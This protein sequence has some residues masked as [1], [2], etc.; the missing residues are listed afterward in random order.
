VEHGGRT[1]TTENSAGDG[2]PTISMK[3]KEA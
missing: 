2:I 3:R 1:E